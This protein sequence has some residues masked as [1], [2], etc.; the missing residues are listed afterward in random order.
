MA[1]TF[2]I[3]HKEMHDIRSAAT[4][5]GYSRDH[6]ATLA[7][8]KKIVA[9]QVGRQWYVDLDS[10]KQYAN[11]TALEQQVKQKHLSDDR[12]FVREL[13]EKLSEKKNR[14]KAQ[15]QLHEQKV[16]KTTMTAAALFL[17]VLGGLSFLS[18]QL[19]TPTNNQLANPSVITFTPNQ[20]EFVA[21]DTSQ[22][23]AQIETVFSDGL[24]EVVSMAEEGEAIVLLPEGETSTSSL[25]SDEVVAIVKE[26]GS[27]VFVIPNQNPDDGIPFVTVPINQVQIP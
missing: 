11:I 23:H 17:S 15:K 9:A 18:P 13:T 4:E 12:R 22:H 25:F 1:R 10:L 8:N 27:R 2:E 21:L 20:T 7:R 26:D 16:R 14:A 6:V 19:F 5:T 3:D 24:V